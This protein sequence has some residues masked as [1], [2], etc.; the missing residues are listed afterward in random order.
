MARVTSTTKRSLIT[1]ANS[2]MV[3]STGV[4]AFVAV[5]CLIASK[6]LISQAGYQNRIISAKKTAVTQLKTNIS[7]RD[8]LVTSY[9]AFVDTPQNVLGGNPNGAGA[10][11][12]DNAKLVL[13]ALPSKYD[14]P[15][16]A[17][18]LEKII[19]SQNLQILGITGTDNEATQQS[20]T[21]TGD[22]QPVA[23]PFQVQVSGSYDQI[24]G[25]VQVFGGS[26]RPFQ[27]QTVELSGSQSNMT[28]T[29][30][31]QTYYQP[32][33]TFKISSEVIK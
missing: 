5:F 24:K 7:A 10:Q 6:T 4:A 27:I 11:D 12:G 28:A 31:A 14:F 25:L 1:Q 26:I 30:T 19:T 17:T 32:E 22:P 21:A 3:V 18:S 9:S 20:T 29:I 13:D 15:A 33:K 23:M 8:S 16:L 2:T